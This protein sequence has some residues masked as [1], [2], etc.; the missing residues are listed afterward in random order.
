V[1]L[2]NSYD[3]WY[4]TVRQFEGLDDTKVLSSNLS[5]SIRY[6]AY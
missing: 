5:L 3:Y 2:G 1:A 4:L 6:Y